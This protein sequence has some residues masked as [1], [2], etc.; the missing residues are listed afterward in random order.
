MRLPV[1][2]RIDALALAEVTSPVIRA[3]FAYWLSKC[4]DGHPPRR[5]D[6]DPVDVPKL[7]PFIVLLDVQPVPLDFCYR[8]MGAAA[9]AYFSAN[10]I[11]RFMSDLPDQ[12]ENSD[13]WLVMQAVAGQGR[14]ALTRLPYGGPLKE[15]HHCE[16][17]VLPLLD[18]NPM[19]R[20]TADRRD[21]VRPRITKLL[22]AIDFLRV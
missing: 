14:T 2:A 16:A 15:I 20:D 12:D 3:A 9:R 10:L 6:L 4:C 19:T 1:L 17:A 7:L 13:L 5:R 8:L 11:G 22:A 21:H 18:D